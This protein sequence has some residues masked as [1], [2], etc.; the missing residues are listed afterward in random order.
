SGRCATRAIHAGRTAGLKEEQ[1]NLLPRAS[2]RAARALG[3]ASIA[4]TIMVLLASTPASAAPEGAILGADSPN[5]VA[6]PYIVVFKDAKM[7]P[8]AV[9]DRAASLARQHGGD[10]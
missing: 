5:A 7:T 9:N 1:M 6:G 8:G 4:T 3:G 2:W 10:V